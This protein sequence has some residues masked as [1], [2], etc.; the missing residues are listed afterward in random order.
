[1]T[2]LILEMGSVNL[3][4][5]GPLLHELATN[6]AALRQLL[7]APGAGAVAADLDRARDAL[8]RS[9]CAGQGR[10]RF[11][12][13]GRPELGPRLE[14][15]PGIGDPLDGLTRHESPGAPIPIGPID[16]NSGDLPRRAPHSAE[17]TAQNGSRDTISRWLRRWYVRIVSSPA[18]AGDVSIKGKA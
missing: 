6:R 10:A 3:E 4:R 7:P 15:A 8:L 14:L 9:T 13:R 2:I 17:S 16:P 12:Q 1:M 5:I 11:Q 18:T